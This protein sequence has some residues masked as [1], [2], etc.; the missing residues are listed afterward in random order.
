MVKVVI[1]CKSGRRGRGMVSERACFASEQNRFGARAL[2]AL[3]MFTLHIQVAM[4]TAAQHS[5]SV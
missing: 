2:W 3:N 1:V 4:R 5:K